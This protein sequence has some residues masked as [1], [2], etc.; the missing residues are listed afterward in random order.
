[1]TETEQLEQAIAA[2]EAQR[3]IL[4]DAVVNTALAPMREKYQALIAE[5][6]QIERL[7]HEGAAKARA[8]ATP[9]LAELRHAVGLRNL[10][11]VATPAAVEKAKAALPQFKQYREADGRFHFKLVDADGRLL[12]QGEGFASPREAG[13]VVAA[14]KAGSAF[15]MKEAALWLAGAQVA[16]LADGVDEATLCAALGAFAD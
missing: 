13:A 4:G 1:M 10:A 2:L 14:L 5:P 15:E 16:M 12:L 11:A 9:F 8:I 7:L 3:A 6:M